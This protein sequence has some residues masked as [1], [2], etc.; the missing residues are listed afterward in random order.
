MKVTDKLINDIFNQKIK[1]TSKKDIDELSKYQNIIP[2]YDIYSHLI[3]PTNF[4]Q[5]EDYIINKHYRFI[6]KPQ[7]DI[8]KNYLDKLNEINKLSNEQKIFQDKIKYNLDIIKNY[9]LDLLEE[10]SIKAFYF[11]SNNLGQ[12]ISICRRK[13]FNPELEHLTPYYNLKEL[14]KMGQNNNL[15]KNKIVPSDLQNEELHYKICKEIS[16]NDINGNEI[17]QHKNYLIK[18]KNIIKFFSIY[19]SFFVNKNLRFFQENN[20][21]KNCPYPIFLDYTKKIIE[22]FNKTPGL[23]DEYFFYRFIQN[24]NFLKNINKGDIFIDGGIMSTTRNP[25]YSPSEFE[26]FGLILL[27]ITVPKEFDKLLLLE[28][29]SAFPSEEEVIFPPFTKL[30]LI[31]KNDIEYFHTNENIEK[32]IK[33]RY[34]FKVVGQSK[35]PLIPSFKPTN[36]PIIN[37]QS[38]LFSETLND[39]KKEFVRTLTNQHNLFD[40]KIKNKNITFVVMTFDST[41][42][43]SDIFSQKDSDGLLLYSFD[44]DYSIKYGIE[45]SNELVF[46]FQE[47]FFP[48]TNDLDDEDVYQILGIIGKLFG[49]DKAK[50]YL[51]YTFDKNIYY[52]KI[53]DTLK[54]FKLFEFRAGFSERDFLSKINSDVQIDNH[55]NKKFNKTFKNWKEYFDNQKNLGTL[56]NFYEYWENNFQQNCQKLFSLVD[57][58]PFYNKN[59]IDF[60]KMVFNKSQINRFRQT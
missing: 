55:P 14:I 29:L 30:Q 26:K 42:A 17:L 46:N 11:G 15:I 8:F 19:G 33:K 23:T 57:L 45:I 52:P 51:N 1:L 58:N 7:K 21:F 10:T 36:I 22:I 56:K 38:K 4:N 50:V 44:N 60:E 39:R 31:S 2:L 3:Y 24:D 20:S 16:I 18:Y 13:S 27:K 43:Y 28:G 6:T 9:N 40:I 5:I 35:I 32:I 54:G 59:N 25:F 47:R 34:H 53:F 12:S 48:D 49:Y 37:L 41:M